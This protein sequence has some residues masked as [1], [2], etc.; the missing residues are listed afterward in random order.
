MSYREYDQGSASRPQSR[1]HADPYGIARQETNR[2]QQVEIKRYRDSDGNQRSYRVIRFSDP[3]VPIFEERTP[4]FASQFGESSRSSRRPEYVDQS[5]R[6]D[7]HQP[8]YEERQP[9]SRREPSE[10]HFSQ[11][12]GSLADAD[13]I[14]VAWQ[15]RR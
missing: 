6:T 3:K 10:S 1:Y 11:R 13:P 9:Q 14:Y 15:I 5:R 12:A 8:A 7:Y 2:S 4:A